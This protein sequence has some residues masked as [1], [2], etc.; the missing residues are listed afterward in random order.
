MLSNQLD[1]RFKLG[2]PAQHKAGYG[3]YPRFGN[4]LTN[5]AGVV[6]RHAHRLFEYDVP[7]GFGGSNAVLG[8]NIGVS[9]GDHNIDAVVF[10]EVI[11]GGVLFAIHPVRLHY[12]RGLLRRFVVHSHHFG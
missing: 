1:H 4:S 8:P 10:K 6:N 2:I 5:L 12:P 7:A 9:T 3:F 11:D